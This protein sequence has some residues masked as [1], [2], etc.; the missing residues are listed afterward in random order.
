MSEG[1]EKNL[2]ALAKGGSIVGMLTL[3]LWI[4]WG[5]LTSAQEKYQEQQM[6]YIQELKKEQDLLR[7]EIK[8]C[9]E[10]NTQLLTNQIE[11][12]TFVLEKIERKI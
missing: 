6:I 8:K 5:A 3:G 9:S 2:V 1:N 10:G 12:N 4:V 7:E 11:R